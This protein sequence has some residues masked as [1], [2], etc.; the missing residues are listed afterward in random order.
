VKA[1]L[2]AVAHLINVECNLEKKT[3]FF[4]SILWALVMH[5][6]FSILWAPKGQDCISIAIFL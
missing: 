4:I 6:A 2:A 3:A 1:N 5:A